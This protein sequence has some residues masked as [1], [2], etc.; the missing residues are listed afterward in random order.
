MPGRATD[1]YQTL[2]NRI[3]A[4]PKFLISCRCGRTYKRRST[5]NYDPLVI[6]IYMI[7]VMILYKDI[8]ANDYGLTGI[9]ELEGE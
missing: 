7:T 9:L 3:T 2:D 4:S 1:N 6:G 5:I 8:S